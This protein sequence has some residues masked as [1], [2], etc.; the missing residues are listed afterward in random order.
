MTTNISGNAAL[1]LPAL[2]EKSLVHTCEIRIDTSIRSLYNKGNGKGIPMQ[3]HISVSLSFP[4][5]VQLAM[6]V[7][8]FI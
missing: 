7:S 6:L 3:V 2:H 8:V 5:L 4:L 1:E